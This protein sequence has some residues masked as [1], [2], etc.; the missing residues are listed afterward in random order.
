MAPVGSLI[1]GRWP[2]VVHG[3][4]PPRGVRLAFQKVPEPNQ[5]KVR[6]H[7]DIGVWDLEAAADQAVALGATRL[8]GV[9]RDGAGAFIVLADPEGHEFC[10]VDP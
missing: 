4:E 1:C 3:G 10:F 6:I 9:Q 7:L 5:G 8:G 2:L